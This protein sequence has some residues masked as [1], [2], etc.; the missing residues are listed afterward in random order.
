MYIL[1]ILISLGLL[2]SVAGVPI[3]AKALEKSTLSSELASALEG[4]N[5]VQIALT[6]MRA[7]QSVVER[8]YR[9]YYPSIELKASQLTNSGDIMGSERST[10]IE[11]IQN[12]YSGGETQAKLKIVELE[13]LRAE[14]VFQKV[15]G[16]QVFQVAK[17]YLAISKLTEQLKAFELTKQA[18]EQLYLDEK[19]RF[20]EGLS[21]V[22][23]QDYVLSRLNAV[24]NRIYQIED[25][26]LK[27]KIQIRKFYPKDVF[28]GKYWIDFNNLPETPRLIMTNNSLDDNLE[29]SIEFQIAEIGYKLADL[30]LSIQKS[31]TKPRVDLIANSQTSSGVSNIRN[32]ND[33]NFSQVGVQVSI[34]LFDGNTSLID[35]EKQE[36]LTESEKIKVFQVKREFVQ[37]SSKALAILELAQK[38]RNVTEASLVQA[39]KLIDQRRSLRE[40]KSDSLFGLVDALV[41]RS[42]ATF[43]WWESQFEEQ[44]SIAKLLQFSN[45]FNS[46]ARVNS[47]FFEKITVE[48]P[49]PILIDQKLSVFTGSRPGGGEI[50]EKLDKEP[51]LEVKLNENGKPLKL[52]SAQFLSEASLRKEQYD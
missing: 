29:N 20:R 11:L 32:L 25:K 38:R 17:A 16:E 49:S 23:E 1:N 34:D 22:L 2:L 30:K 47:K 41:S 5:E 31:R 14:K 40:L 10:T 27:A 26:L 13:G 28:Q 45:R 19:E 6:E 4:A 18:L 44:I 12:L 50:R 48:K 24:N 7:F 21:T 9:L 15:L 37:E 36:L 46:L 3:E 52:I 43:N 8:K 39:Q 33:A 51:E 42:E 35:S